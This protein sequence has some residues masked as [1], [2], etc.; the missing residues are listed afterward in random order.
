MPPHWRWDF[1]RWQ[2]Q[3]VVVNLMTNDY[4]PPPPASDV[5]LATWLRELWLTTE[6]LCVTGCDSTQGRMTLVC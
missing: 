5:L 6:M 4:A 2:P 3:L 1:A